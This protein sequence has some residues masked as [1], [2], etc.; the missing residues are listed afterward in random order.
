[1]LVF[2]FLMAYAIIKSSSLSESQRNVDF[3]TD[4][5]KLLMKSEDIILPI[6]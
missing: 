5:H 4:Q 2:C 6:K 3:D 1:M